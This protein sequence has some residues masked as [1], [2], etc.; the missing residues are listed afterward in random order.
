MGTWVVAI[1]RRLTP[2]LPASILGHFS[3]TILGLEVVGRVSEE[4]VGK[5][6]GVAEE[7]ACGNLVIKPSHASKLNAILPS[8]AG[9]DREVLE[10]ALSMLGN[11]S[12]ILLLR[13]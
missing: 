2:P 8:L 11:E 10:S 3:G 7:D 9:R 1:K 13:K 6:R 5:V 4:A 12:E